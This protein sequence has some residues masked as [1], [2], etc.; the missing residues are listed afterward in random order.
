MAMPL[1]ERWTIEQLDRLPDDGNRYELLDGEL[2][3]TPAPSDVHEE[4]VSML[5]DVLIP[6]VSTHG[7]GGVQT[8]GVMKL[9]GSQLEPDLIVRPSAPLR[10]WENAP[11]P[12]L[13]V[14]VL[15]RSTRVRDTGKKRTFYS[16]TG[17]PEY[18]IVDREEEV[19]IVVR[20]KDERRVSSTL[21]WSP[22]GVSAS[23]DIDV[24][25]VF[26]E[27]KSRM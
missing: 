16:G 15:S 21:R 2:L 13:V 25:K 4:L 1:T 17:I 26:A 11:L 9:E 6:F 20:G 22:A 14:E 3:V 8:R 12:I 10:G 18:W 23:L 7:L 5:R 24:A 19:V 27:I